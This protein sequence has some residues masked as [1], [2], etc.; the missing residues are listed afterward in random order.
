MKNLQFIVPA[1]ACSI[2]VGC[3]EYSE[4]DQISASRNESAEQPNFGSATDV[5]PTHG[6]SAETNNLNLVDSGLGGA[7]QRQTGNYQNQPAPGQASDQELAKQIKIALTTGSMGTTGA[8]AED[9]L[10]K[11]DVKVR[12]GAVVLS[13]PVASEQEKRT[14]EKQ[15]AGMKGV[16]SVR[17]LLTVGGRTVQDNIQPLVPRAPGNQ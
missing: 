11:I 17:N 4:G 2:F 16:R 7:P 6:R 15:V 3:G 10:T 13:G 8:I 14:I 12:N 1:L 9:Q 5:T